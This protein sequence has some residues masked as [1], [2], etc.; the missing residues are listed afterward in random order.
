MTMLLG[1]PLVNVLAHL[2]SK[3][4]AMSLGLFQGVCQKE[5]NQIW[6]ILS[7]LALEPTLLRRL[8]C[9]WRNWENLVPAILMRDCGQHTGCSRNFVMQR[10]GI[11]HV[12]SG[13]SKSLG[14]LR[15]Q[16]YIFAPK[17]LGQWGL[18]M[19]I[20]AY[21]FYSVNSCLAE[22]KRL[23]NERGWEGARHSSGVQVVG[24]TCKGLGYCMIIQCTFLLNHKKPI[25]IMKNYG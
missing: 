11:L 3:P 8:W 16:V 12:K 4:L 19:Y 2:L 7:I 15:A 23:S 21:M 22:D 24:S 1:G 25:K 17:T 13:A 14:C 6:F 20:Y 9:G 10:N 18:H 5:S